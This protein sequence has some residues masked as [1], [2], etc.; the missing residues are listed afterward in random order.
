MTYLIWISGGFETTLLNE[1]K[2][3]LSG[4][5]TTICSTQKNYRPQCV[6]QQLHTTDKAGTILSHCFVGC[7]MV[8]VNTFF[9]FYLSVLR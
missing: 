6:L 1:F 3:I 4:S 5:Q 7:R 8:Q 9:L 2:H